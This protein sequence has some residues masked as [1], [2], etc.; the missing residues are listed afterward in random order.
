MIVSLFDRGWQRDPYA[1]A[2]RKGERNWTYDEV[3]R[4]SCRLANAFLVRPQ[5]SHVGVLA[6]NDPAAWE[7]ILGAWRAGRTWVPMNPAYPA[8]DTAAA[9][10]AFDVDV[11]FFHAALLDIVIDTAPVVGR[12]VVWVCIDCDDTPYPGI[13]D[14]VGNAADEPPNVSWDPDDVVAIMPTGGTT[15]RPKGVMNTHRTLSV[16]TTHLMLAFAYTADEPI[17]NVAAAPMTHA[18]GLLTL[19]CLARGGT[20]VVLDSAETD[21]V[22]SAL[23]EHEATEIFLPPTSI[24]RL[25]AHPDLDVADLGGL[26]YLLYG[27]APMAV[28]RLREA[29][30]RLGPVLIGGYGQMEAPMAISFLTPAEHMVG[31]LVAD[32]DRLSSCGRPSPL[33]QVEIRDDEGRM[34]PPGSPGEICVRGDLVMKGYYRQSDLTDH[35]VIDGWLHTGD[36]GLLDRGGYLHITDRKKD[37]IITGGSNVYPSDVERVLA[38]HPSV[39]ECA[40][41]GIPDDDW[42]ERVV[43]FVELRPGANDSP[44][45]LLCWGR[46]RLGGLRAPKQIHVVSALPRTAVGKVAKA[47]LRHAEPGVGTR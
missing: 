11:V 46:T 45:D 10:D 25:L 18:A 17:V 37:M 40:V 39:Q 29:V 41:V 31:G 47:A 8:A 36:I 32:D 5:L 42:G 15:G 1:V 30:E 34:V 16:A 27:A 9:I 38:A 4:T 12:A 6:N 22:L 3:R 24:Y 19:P 21:G 14:W 26:R 28:P 2:Y 20:V 13:H 23:V 35:T 33:V 43:A 44:H 7:I